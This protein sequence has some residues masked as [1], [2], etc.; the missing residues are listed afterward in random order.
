[1]TSQRDFIKR[2]I[3]ARNETIN[4]TVVSPPKL[5]YFSVGS[6]APVWVADVAIGAARVL[7][8]VPIKAGSDGSRFFADLGQVVLLRRNMLE[9]F[10]IIGPGDRKAATA[11][12]KTYTIGTP[13]PIATTNVGFSILVRPFSFYQGGLIVPGTDP[14]SGLWGTAGFPKIQIIDD[15]TG[16]PV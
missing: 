12:K 11:V 16:Q 10:Q 15:S 1:M 4:G 9:K 3:R 13:T 2:E 14:D 6:T 7:R 8:N 5:R